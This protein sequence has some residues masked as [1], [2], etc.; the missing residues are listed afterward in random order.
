[1]ADPHAARRRPL[2]LE[3]LEA[4]ELLSAAPWL[5]EPFQRGPVS[6]L[7]SGWNQWAS[8]GTRSF[9]VSAGA[10][11][12]DTGRLVTTAS[13]SATARA[14]LAAPYAA[15]VE[16]SAAVFLNTTVPVQ[17]FV[18]GRDLNTPTPSYYAVG[19]T[20]GAEVQLLKVVRGRATVLGAVKTDD[21]VS[22]KWAT[23][24][25][26]AEG[27]RLRVTLHR[28][29][30]NQYLAADGSW[31]R[32]PTA[33]IEATDTAIRGAGQVGF[34]RA[35]KV[36]GEV[37]LDSLRVGA[38]SAPQQ[39][40]IVEERFARAANALPM[41]WTQ[42]NAPAKATFA[43]VADETLR[44]EAGSTSAARAYL[45]NP[46][47]ADS[48][49]S[50]SI[51]LDSLTPAGIFARG[52]NLSGTT[53]TYYGLTVTRGL[54]VKLTRVVNGVTTE[55]GSIRS[56]EWLSGL[57]VQASLV[58]NGDKLR[59]QVYRSDT[60]QYLNPNGTWGLSPGWAMTKTDTA[61]RSGGR[62][63]LSRGTGYAGPLV[64]DNF[65]VTTAPGATAAAGPIPTEGDKATT[66]R[67]PEDTPA[68]T[69][70]PTPIPTPT[71]RP[72]P[73]PTPSNPAL[74]AVPR[75]YDWIRLANLAYYGT[76]IGTTEKA[77]LR[78]SVDL[79]IPNLTYLD[80]IA[81]VAPQT[82]QF[83][84]TNVSNIY[85][86]LLT[87]WNEYADRNRLNREGA[88]YHVT[89]ATTFNGASASSVPVNRF[90]GVHRG[91]D[92]AGWE[93]LTSNAR[94]ATNSFA[95]AD[96]GKAITFG[97]LE[98]FREINVDLKTG[99]AG[100][101]RAQLEYVSAVD[102]N[103]KPTAWKTLSRTARPRTRRR[104]RSRELPRV[105]DEELVS[106]ATTGT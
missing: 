36:A 5:V 77:L 76:P 41:G 45:N 69:P 52:S 18:R 11:L 39:A 86:G 58:M 93:D 68:P 43:T 99:A 27:D 53:P 35:A 98:K 64:F 83:I 103:G 56:Q 61:I 67:P 106:Q 71:P 94:N 42:W 33:V 78:N 55:L 96:N 38:P 88:F 100:N 46:V 66:P 60:G 92:S 29:D 3:G 57:W 32:Q 73:T 59:V 13:S 22:G 2:S 37:A 102:A 34:A 7:P 47:A 31:T 104:T 10:G 50:S 6:G 105:T 16:T 49:I 12:G 23:V 62:V 54:E 21:Y 91:S 48:Q 19:V 40:P 28:G 63:G 44:V 87:D 14:W 85:L 4:R 9:Q 84:Y 75:H 81:S 51:Y 65:I 89:K 82:P 15:D 79:V 74:P 30:T 70:T 80:D 1:M 26:R 20:R 17:L 95:F 90:W 101:W 72:T 97:F 8:D 24:R 25:I